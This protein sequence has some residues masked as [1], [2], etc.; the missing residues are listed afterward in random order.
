VAKVSALK[1]ADKKASPK[2]SSVDKIIELLLDGIQRGKIVPGQRLIT[3]E[4][5]KNMGTS[6]APVRE[7]FHLL[8]GQG[9]LELLPNR[10]AR[11]RELTTEN[12][13]EGVQILQ[14]VGGLAIRLASKNKPNEAQTKALDAIMG[15]IYQAGDD[16]NATEFFLAISASHR[17]MNE[18]AGNS[19]LNPVVGRLHLEYFNSQLATILPGN[20]DRYLSNYRELGALATTGD[21]KKLEKMLSKHFDWV[22]SILR[23]KIEHE[24]S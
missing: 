16:R 13:L 12:L 22:M 7:A 2:P 19:Y 17:Y 18:L 1:D 11:V 9:L 6:L 14:V 3:S 5:S 8:A 21:Y 23:E 24:Q 20:W 15:R 10:G 4:L